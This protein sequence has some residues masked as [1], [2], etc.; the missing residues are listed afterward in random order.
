[1][2]KLYVLLAGICIATGSMA[3]TDTTQPSLQHPDTIHVGN[4]LIIKYGKPASDSGY[5]TNVY[6]HRHIK[7][8]KKNENVTTNWGILDLGFSNF[9]DKTNYAGAAAQAIAPGSNDDWFNLR[10][11]KSVNVNFWIF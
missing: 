7:S 2:H 5:K 4:L 8:R 9:T 11:G 3:Q 1:M 6:F 10:N